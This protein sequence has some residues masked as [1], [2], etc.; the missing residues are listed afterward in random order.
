[1]VRE[2]GKNINNIQMRQ[3]KDQDQLRGKAATPS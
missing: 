2:M 3:P 1:M